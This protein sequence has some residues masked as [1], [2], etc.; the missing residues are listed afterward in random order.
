METKKLELLLDGDL[1]YFDEF[2]QETKQKVFYNIYS[3]LKDT[4][5]SEDALQ[6]TYIKFLKNRENLKK[7]QN[8]I[9]YLFVISRNISLDI[10]KKRKKETELS[11][12]ELVNAH[13]EKS[14]YVDDVME[15]MKKILKDQEFQIVIMHLVNDMTHKEIAKLLN[16]PLGTITWAYNNAIKKIRKG[17]RINEG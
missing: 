3:I 8:I 17:M 11:D 2:Y 13:E 14:P 9:G 12:Y 10:I 6:E 1:S 7:D 4:S 5:L 15:K 16:K